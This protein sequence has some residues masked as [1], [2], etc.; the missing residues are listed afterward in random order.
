M[1][2]KPKLV[3]TGPLTVVGL[4]STAT[5]N[6]Y[7]A[8]R[9]KPFAVAEDDADALVRRYGDVLRRVATKPKGMKGKTDAGAGAEA[10]SERETP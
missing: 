7:A 8:E 2:T 4:T 9:G 1:G 3:Y 10:N 6:V 5:G